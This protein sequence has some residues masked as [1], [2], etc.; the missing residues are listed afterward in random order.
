MA[1]CPCQLFV[2]RHPAGIR[3][4]QPLHR[5]HT[6]DVPLAFNVGLQTFSIFA[7]QRSVRWK[8]FAVQ[9]T[10]CGKEN[11]AVAVPCNICKKMQRRAEVDFASAVCLYFVPTKSPVVFMLI[12]T[13]VSPV[14]V[15]LADSRLHP[16]SSRPTTMESLN[17]ILLAK[18]FVCVVCIRP[19][20]VSRHYREL[21]Y[22]T[23]P[24]DYWMATTSVSTTSDL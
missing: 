15:A 9:C 14:N 17:Q 1:G 7:V 13:I 20:V 16:G 19:T 23:I 3:S 5:F 4:I 11:G 8:K 21:R 10:S 2:Y 22:L 18:Y 24:Q 12:S 6:K